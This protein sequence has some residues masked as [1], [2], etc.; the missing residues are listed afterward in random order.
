M[1]H[2]HGS[3]DAKQIKTDHQTQKALIYQTYE[4]AYCKECDHPFLCCSLTMHFAQVPDAGK[5]NHH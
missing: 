1:N 2:S 3:L 4:P 5:E